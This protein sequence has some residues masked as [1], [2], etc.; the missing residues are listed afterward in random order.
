MPHRAMTEILKSL[1]LRGIAQPLDDLTAQDSLSIRAS[2]PFCLACWRQNPLSRKCT[3]R[4][5]R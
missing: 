4:P 3:R 5:E 1:T 2:F